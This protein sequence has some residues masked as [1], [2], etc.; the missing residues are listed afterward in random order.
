MTTRATI[1]D[2]QHDAA[3]PRCAYAY[4]RTSSLS[5]VGGDSDVRQR[6]AIEAYAEREGIEI[7]GEFYDAG[8]K[9]GDAIEAR[10]GFS[11]MLAAIGCDDSV[12]MI[13]VENASRFARTLMVQEAGFA[14]LKGLGVALVPVDN[15]YH[16][17]AANDDP[18]VNAFRQFVGIMNELEKAMTVAKL[19]GARQ[20]KRAATGRCEGPRQAP[21]EC[22][23]L[24]VTMRSEGLAL[25]KIGERLAEAGY[26][27]PAGNVYN[28]SSVKAMI[29][30]GRRTAC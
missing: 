23:R 10:P 2:R 18:M 1:E 13:L 26:R 12:R 8:V 9:G 22:R 3:A 28:G 19:R 7:A 21:E 24:A 6:V 30:P 4:L 16:F 14:K 15:P 20:R 27:T 5:N 17:T 11:D 29:V 25:A